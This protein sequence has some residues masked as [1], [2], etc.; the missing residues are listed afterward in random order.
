MVASEE[1]SV[2]MEGG[3]GS[4]SSPTGKDGKTKGGVSPSMGPVP[5][6]GHVVPPYPPPPPPHHPGIHYYRPYPPPPGYEHSLPQQ[7]PATGKGSKADASAREA[8]PLGPYT[9]AQYELRKQ[10]G[11]PIA[12]PHYPGSAAAAATG[13]APSATNSDNPSSSKSKSNNGSAPSG[14]SPNSP[15]RSG[16]KGRDPPPLPPHHYV[17]PGVSGGEHGPPPPHPPAHHHPGYPPYRGEEHHRGPHLPPPHHRHWGD[18]N[19]YY[20]GGSHLYPP[21]PPPHSSQY[22][23]GGSDGR[24][25]PIASNEAPGVKPNPSQLALGPYRFSD[26]TLRREALSHLRAKRA[27]QSGNGSGGE[28]LSDAD[29]RDGATSPSQIESSHRDEVTTMGCTCK[30]TKCLKLYCQ[31]FA[32]K[33]YCG[34]NCRCMVCQNTSLYDRERQEAIRNILSRNPQA[35]DTK[36]KKAVPDTAAP[37]LAH[38]LGC[39]CRKSACM[40]KYCECYAG[41]VKCSD[42]CRCVGCKNMGRPDGGPNFPPHHSHPVML[43]PMPTAQKGPGLLVAAITAGEEPRK[44][45]PYMMDAAHNLVRNT[46]GCGHETRLFMILTWW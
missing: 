35:F 15:G 36:F 34:S 5:S 29:G 45:E 10:S 12:V 32:V 11:P 37:E 7:P 3:Q 16:A 40:K 25:P 8:P 13:A 31:C 44:R 38:K 46:L 20:E 33:I 17:H 19:P 6:V 21:P 28:N 18:Y 39:K 23:T 4:P 22:R 42:S 24:Q 2:K 9:A 1:A 30:K 14:S 27:Q 41:M 26:T 43:A